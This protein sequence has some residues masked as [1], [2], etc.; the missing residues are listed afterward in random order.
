MML[1][2]YSEQG[3]GRSSA[4][5][6]KPASGGPAAASSSAPQRS[7]SSNAAVHGTT[8]TS[9]ATGQAANNY[10][11]IDETTTSL[12]D[13]RD[14]PDGRLGKPRESRPLFP[15]RSPCYTSSTLEMDG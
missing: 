11:I 3:P 4:G 1:K 2:S 8:T 12:W 15:N 14:G 7:V 6:R 5:P 9:H 10:G 13:L